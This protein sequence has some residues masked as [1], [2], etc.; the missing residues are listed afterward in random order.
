MRMLCFFLESVGRES[1]GL[2]RY[3]E[4]KVLDLPDFFVRVSWR[5]AEGTELIHPWKSGAVRRLSEASLRVLPS[6]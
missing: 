1:K 5:A 6:G 3:M 2:D 4:D